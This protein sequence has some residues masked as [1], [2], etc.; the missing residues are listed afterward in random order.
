MASSI[1]HV[2]PLLLKVPYFEI[3]MAGKRWSPL[4]H[5]LVSSVAFTDATDEASTVTIQLA[6][7]DYILLDDNNLVRSTKMKVYGGY[8]NDNRLWLEGYIS[9]VDVNFQDSGPPLIEITIMDESF[10]MDNMPRYDVYKDMSS[11][12]I[13]R[14]IAGMYGLKFSGH[15][16]PRSYK[17]KVQ[18]KQTDIKFLQDL[19]Q[20]EWFL[21]KVINGT[22]YWL[23]R[24]FVGQNV[25]TL[26]FRRPP[27]D[28]ISFNPRLVQAD[29]M[30]GYI[31]TTID[32]KTGKVTKTK[33]GNNGKKTKG[34]VDGAGPGDSSGVDDVTLPDL[35]GLLGSMPGGSG[36]GNGQM[37]QY[38][39]TTGE[40]HL[41]GGGNRGG[42]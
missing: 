37:M 25:G 33:V 38:D 35:G 5:S 29:R 23:E 17:R 36:D 3:W 32:P 41:V 28:V 21:I 7:P 9:S 40:W 14:K 8:V 19:A 24:K 42:R 22:L 31:E 27:Y 4:L 13:A 16:G 12:Q 11:D 1:V 2:D 15:K 39:P 30:D 20:D 26:W 10:S 6:D 18:S 34:A